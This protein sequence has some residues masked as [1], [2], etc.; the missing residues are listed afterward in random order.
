MKKLDGKNFVIFKAHNIL[1][2][3]KKEFSDY[4]YNLGETIDFRIYDLASLLFAI[5]LRVLAFRSQDC[6]IIDKVL[7]PEIMKKSN[8]SEVDAI[9]KKALKNEEIFLE[10]REKYA[11]YIMNYLEE[12][13]EELEF[14]I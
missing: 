6:R 1:A 11:S 3:E 14:K 8:F 7:E 2:V 13:A 12:I 10:E 4:I 9:L 5:R